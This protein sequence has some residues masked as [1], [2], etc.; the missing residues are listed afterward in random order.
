MDHR[1]IQHA[2][3]LCTVSSLDDGAFFTLRVG[4]DPGLA[5]VR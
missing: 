4:S 2:E 1:T 5:S 3:P